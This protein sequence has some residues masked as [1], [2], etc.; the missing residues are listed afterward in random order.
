MQRK[1]LAS[2]RPASHPTL[3]W[4]AVTHRTIRITFITRVV[5]A[6]LCRLSSLP[7]LPGVLPAVAVPVRAATAANTDG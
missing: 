4:F 7:A 1:R 2:A 5:V 6:S 3:H